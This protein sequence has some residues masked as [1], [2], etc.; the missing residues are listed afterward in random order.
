MTLTIVQGCFPLDLE[1]YRPKS[2]YSPS[3]NNVILG[4]DPHKEVN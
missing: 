2:A 4:F 3:F 1:P